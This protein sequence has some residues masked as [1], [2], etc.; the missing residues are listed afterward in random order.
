MLKLFLVLYM[1]FFN[2][3]IIAAVT[4]N[5]ATLRSDILKELFPEESNEAIEKTQLTDVNNKMKEIAATSKT[6]RKNLY[7]TLIPKTPLYKSFLHVHS[8][9]KKKINK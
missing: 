6:D 3:L 9:L 4:P 8:Q 1:V 7:Q 5:K 2:L